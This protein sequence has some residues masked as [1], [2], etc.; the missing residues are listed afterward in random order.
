MV[1]STSAGCR[2]PFR[3]T[4]PMAPL[5]SAKHGRRASQEHKCQ[6]STP[7]VTDFSSLLDE[8]FLDRDLA[9]GT[10]VKGNCDGHR[11]RQWPSSMW[12]F[13]VEGRVPLKEFGAKAKD[14]NAEARR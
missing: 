13:K 11:K 12:A 9:E 10:V 1:A 2:P 6:N 5:R 4:N 3:N 14:G 8:S 7:A